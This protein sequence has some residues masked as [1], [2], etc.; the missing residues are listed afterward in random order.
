VEI[1]LFVYILSTSFIAGIIG[2]LLGLGG[3][4]ILVPALTILFDLPI[5]QAIGVSFIGVLV[6]SSSSSIVYIKNRITDLRLSSIL[7]LGAV[8][9][10]I[11]GAYTA[12]QI[13]SS[14]LS[15]IFGIVLGYIAINM[16]VKSRKNSENN[17]IESKSNDER[18]YFDEST[19]EIITYSVKREK[20]G[21][22][23]SVIGGI[24]SGLLGLGGGAIFVPIMNR[25]MNI[26]IKVAIAT[27]SFMIGVTSLVGALI[28]F[29]NG[30]IDVTLVSPIILGI[31]FGAQ[32]GSR[33][34]KVIDKQILTNIFCIV[35]IYIALRMI[36][37]GLEIEVLNL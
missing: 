3:G 4:I 23:I 34:N 32:I 1:L 24:F 21:T 22:I 27:S 12:L 9:G 13:D 2:S 37:N 16:Y 17:N 6:N 20:E 11:I 33:I 14:I 19:N 29:N 31:F 7:E 28:F 15:V 36:I 5:H 35:L 25:I 18:K 10:S 30:L 26:P 8:T